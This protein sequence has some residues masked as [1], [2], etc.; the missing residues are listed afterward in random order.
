MI[1]PPPPAT[2]YLPFSRLAKAECKYFGRKKFIFLNFSFVWKF[3][4]L[5]LHCAV[6][7]LVLPTVLP[8]MF[9]IENLLMLTIVNAASV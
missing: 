6:F 7:V 8:A 9:T 4:Y 1:S 2:L 5:T 3:V